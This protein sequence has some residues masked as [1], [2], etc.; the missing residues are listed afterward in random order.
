MQDIELAHGEN[1]FQTAEIT[2]NEKT[3]DY[4]VNGKITYINF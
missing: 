1:S 3:I 4:K 2:P